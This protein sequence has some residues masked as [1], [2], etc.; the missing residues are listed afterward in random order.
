MAAVKRGV[1]LGNAVAAALKAERVFDA[2]RGQA[3]QQALERVSTARLRVALLHAARIDRM[4]KG[5]GQGDA[6]DEFLQ[7]ALRV[8]GTKAKR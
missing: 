2:R 5:L 3:I 7:L 1:E 4:I 6:W 8:T